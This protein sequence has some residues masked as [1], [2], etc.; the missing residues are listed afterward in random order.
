M[1]TRQ[2]L[3]VAVVAAVC[4]GPV[5]AAKITFGSQHE[6]YVDGK[7]LLPVHCWATETNDLDRLAAMGVN[8][9]YLSGAAGLAWNDLTKG[10]DG[11]AWAL[12]TSDLIGFPQEMV[13][14]IRAMAAEKTGLPGEC[15]A[16]SATHTHSGPSALQVYS[17]ELNEIDHAYRRELEPKL[18][19]VIAD[20]FD[21]AAPGSFEVAMTEAGE[22][23]SNRRVVDA[24]GSATNDWQDPEGKHDGYFDPSVMLIGVR[25]PDGRLAAL[26]VNYGVH[27]VTL[28]PRSLAISAD[29]PGYMKDHIEAACD[30]AV[31]MFA[32]AG[33]GNINPRVCIEVGAQHPKAM[34]EALGAIVVAAAASLAPVA[35]GPVA[36]SL[37]PWKMISRRQWPDSSPR[38]QDKEITSEVMALR[39]G[40]LA[41]VTLPGELF[42]QYV[43]MIRQGSP[44]PH[45]AVISIAND[46]TGYLPLDEA[47]SQGGHEITHRAADA[48]EEPLMAHAKAA[49]TEVA[50]TS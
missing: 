18:A 39:A 11:A 21:A 2:L 10:A 37:H 48:M 12:L 40:D 38:T 30:G 27:P 20:A 23:A 9:A 16:I 8:V 3:A 26:M 31:A 50:G 43:G 14:R 32:L 33:A 4:I 36:C 44:L 47:L 1:R 28:G 24:D 7:L 42:S 15:I 45:T 25:R 6:M 13:Q 5:S 46:S 19:R 34:G 17:N 22:L 29:Y 35:D 49:L 41:W